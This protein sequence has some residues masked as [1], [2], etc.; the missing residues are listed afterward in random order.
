MG[1]AGNMRFLYECLRQILRYDKKDEKMSEIMVQGLVMLSDND[2]SLW[3]RW[4]RTFE[5]DKKWISLLGD[6]LP[7]LHE[8]ALTV[9]AQT[10]RMDLSEDRTGVIDQEL[11]RVPPEAMERILRSVA[12]PLYQRWKAYLHGMKKEKN[13]LHEMKFG[14]YIDLIFLS[15]MHLC[16][17]SETWEKEISEVASDLQSAMTEWYPD[18]VRMETVFFAQVSQLYLLLYAGRE[19]KKKPDAQLI[20]LLLATEKQLYM[21][22]YFWK[23][24]KAGEYAQR[25]SLY[26]LIASFTSAAALPPS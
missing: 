8:A 19:L 16:Q 24:D 5:Y 10:I 20:K 22:E 12:G 1:A 3:K 2:E 25:E 14:G 7:C 17:D 11:D 21:Q 18:V 26:Q 23:A 9:Y 13:G 4:I 6:V 15:V